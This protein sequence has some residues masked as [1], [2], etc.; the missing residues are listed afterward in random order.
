MAKVENT[1]K[2]W[3]LER[4][5]DEKHSKYFGC[6]PCSMQKGTQKKFEF[7]RVHRENAHIKG[8]LTWHRPLVRDSVKLF[9]PRSEEEGTRQRQRRVLGRKAH[10]KDSLPCLFC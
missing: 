8:F 9:L 4:G 2:P 6:L 10:G 3:V 5:K 1:A 7:C